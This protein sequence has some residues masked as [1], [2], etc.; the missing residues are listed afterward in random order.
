MDI[1]EAQPLSHQMVS[2]D[3]L[4]D[5]L[6]GGPHCQGEDLQE[7]KDFTSVSNTAAGK[8]ADDEWVAHHLSVIQ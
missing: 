5:L 6:V 3:E 7:R 1:N 4:E 8:L 2:L